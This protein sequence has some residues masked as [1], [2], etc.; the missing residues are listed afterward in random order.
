[1]DFEIKKLTPDLAEAYARFFDTTPHDD[2]TD[3]A[4]LPCY[5]VTWRGDDS[6]RGDGDHWYATHEER[7]K[8]AISFIKAGSLQGYLAYRGDEIVG[9]CNA[10]AS[11]QLCLSYLRSFWPIDAF[12]P[13]IHV[14]SVFCF[15]IAPEVQRMGVATK[16]LERVCQDAAREGC[17]FVEAY[18]YRDFAAEPFDFRG[19]MA[20]YQKCGFS[21]HAVREGKVVMRK[22][23]NQDV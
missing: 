11:C 8:R 13:D 20:M 22:A 3:K 18:A 1:M 7:R 2:R 14:K 16:L 6:Y 21:V 4:A 17:Q 23:M 19:P 9:W 10:N 15:M 5:C 12:R